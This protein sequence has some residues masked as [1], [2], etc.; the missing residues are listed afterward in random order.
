MLNPEFIDKIYGVG[1]YV[2]V[3]CSSEFSSYFLSAGYNVLNV[4]ELS[5][6]NFNAGY[7]YDFMVVNYSSVIDNIAFNDFISRC[8]H[9]LNHV[10]KLLITVDEDMQKTSDFICFHTM[11]KSS[12]FRY[13]DVTAELLELHALGQLCIPLISLN[14][15]SYDID[16][17]KT[18]HSIV[19][20]TQYVRPHEN[21]CLIY[22][23]G[24]FFA[25]ILSQRCIFKDIKKFRSAEAF[26]KGIRIINDINKVNDKE[27]KKY[28]DCIFVLNKENDITDLSSLVRYTEN[29][30]PGGRIIFRSD[31][32][33][34]L[35]PDRLFE[36]EV[37]YISKDRQVPDNTS[38]CDIVQGSLDGY[39]VAMKNPLIDI[40]KFEYIEKT[41]SYSSPPKNLIMFERDYLN[42]W[43]LKAVVEFPTR[44]R[45]RFA[46]KRYAKKILREYD[47]KL[48][49]YAAAIAILGYQAFSEKNS[50]PF[51]LTEINNY[52]KVVNQIKKKSPHQIRWLISLSVLGAEISKLQNKKNEALNLYLAALSYPYEKFSPTIGTKVLQAYY[53]IAMMLYTSGDTINCEKYLSE[54]LERGIDILN[55]SYKELLGSQEKPLVF[56]LFIYH[57]IIDWLIKLSNLKNNLGEH[58][59]IIPLLNDQT[60]SALLK[61]R[62]DAIKNMNSMIKE[63]DDTI[64]DQGRM[65]EERMQAINELELVIK[66]QQKLV[67]ERWDAMQ[68]M[69]KMIIERDNTI[70]ELKNLI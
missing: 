22:E 42:P 4:K 14:L 29:L 5:A 10:K 47:S 65:L 6:G 53:N 17:K 30:C 58:D 33:Q 39:F 26:F 34:D 3:N 49:D 13:D 1:S 45:N 19:E 12:G 68:Q 20:L 2:F 15:K 50:I 66:S 23:G 43:L 51:V 59:N 54:G 37:A 60:W 63:R 9:S 32:F 46:L 18:E 57:D 69:E 28:F 31:D 41:Y 36:L 61:E 27:K 24:D 21:V 40:Q 16:D 38:G 48:P 64:V 62:M 7:K 44:N 67:E 55:V 25:S 11:I 52:I 56:T 35:A 70:S 8:L